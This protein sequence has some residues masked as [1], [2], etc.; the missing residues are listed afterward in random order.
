MELNRGKSGEADP[1]HITVVKREYAV[2]ILREIN[3]PECH[4]SLL[5]PAV[6][7]S[8]PDRYRVLLLK[9]VD[10]R[11]RLNILASIS[12][13]VLVSFSRLFRRSSKYLYRPKSI[14]C[15]ARPFFRHEDHFRLDGL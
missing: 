13:G 14:V 6:G 3:A 10:E 2:G 12:F 11:N 7:S 8:R 1:G 4:Q 9:N 15:Q 5:L